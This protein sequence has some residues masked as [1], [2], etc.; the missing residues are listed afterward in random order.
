M[1][2]IS[3]LLFAAACITD[4]NFAAGVFVLLGTL[5]AFSWIGRMYQTICKNQQTLYEQQK[6]IIRKMVR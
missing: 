4:N 5:I 2:Y 1:S 6:K 3:A